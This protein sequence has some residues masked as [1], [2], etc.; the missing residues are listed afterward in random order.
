LIGLVYY[1]HHNYHQARDEEIL[2]RIKEREEAAA[3]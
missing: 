3:T 1:N 2:R